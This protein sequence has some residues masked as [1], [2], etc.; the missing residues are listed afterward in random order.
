MKHWNL[1]ILFFC[2]GIIHLS[3]QRALPGFTVQDLGKG[4]V[5]ISW[6]NP[7]PTCNQLAVQRSTDGV[8]FRTIFSAQS[9]E[10][11]RNGYVD[12]K[13]PAAPKVYYRI[14]YVLAGGNYFFTTIKTATD[15]G[16]ADDKENVKKEEDL[17]GRIFIPTEP[18]K[19][20]GLNKDSAAAKETT[21]RMIRLY[22]RGQFLYQLN[23]QA[24]KNFRD[25]IIQF[26]QDSLS[27]IKP[28]EIN[29]KPFIPKPKEYVSVFVKDT[30]LVQ[31]EYPLYKRFKDSV[32]ANTK[33]TLINIT[34]FRA[35]LSRFIPKFVWKPSLHVYTNANGY[36]NIS[37][38]AQDFQAYRI[39][40][41]DAEGKE[42]FRVNKIK[43]AELI[44]DKANF[45]RS[46]WY[47]FELYK[48]NDLVEKNKFFLQKD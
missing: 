3:A 45:K 27:L 22:K 6:I 48:H 12:N 46:G 19:D 32:A 24:Y 43:E 47:D 9:P 20:N 7:Y 34:T 37:L 15:P 4:K 25:S 41:F 33:D 1:L 23:T 16:D 42:L 38:P 10:L 26:T 31:V 36:L 30:L 21:E 5:S 2:C 35:E 18:I 39:V 14:F 40:F 44:L 11:P 17:S 28:G 29:W 8:N 13:L